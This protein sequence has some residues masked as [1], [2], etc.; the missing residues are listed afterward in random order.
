MAT[1]RLGAI[2]GKRVLVVGA[3]EM[4]EGVAVALVGAG[5]TDITVTN[6]THERA[7]T[8]A[9]AGG[10]RRRAV[11]RAAGARWPTPTCCSRAAG[12]GT[13][14][15]DADLVAVARADVGRSPAA[16]RRHR[17]A[18]QRRQRGRACCPASPCSISTTCATGRP[19]ASSCAPHEAEHVRRIVGEE[20]ERFGIETTARQAAPLVAAAARAR[21][22]GPHAPSSSAS[23]PS[24]R[25]S[26]RRSAPP[27]RR[28]PRASSPSCCTSR[29]CA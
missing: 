16:D 27:S 9:A 1:E 2:A 17:R 28:S 6:R 8:L 7:V 13:I 18:A 19:R 22:A 11:R 15:I 3:G 26:S 21:R 12:A 14:V 20:V 4:G 24:S 25:R 23:R 10:R 5:A 29:R